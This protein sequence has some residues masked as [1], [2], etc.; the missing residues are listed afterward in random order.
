VKLLI[1]A[2]Q[3]LP[4]ISAQSVRISQ[5]ARRFHFKD[6]NL[7]IKIVVFDPEG[8]KIGKNEGSEDGIE[9]ERFNRRLLPASLLKPQSLNPL[10]LALW[11]YIASKEIKDFN[12]DVVLA[13]TPPFTPSIATYVASRIAGDEVAYAIDYRDDLGRVI[14]RM[15]ND[16]G[17]WIKYPLKAA[18]WIMSFLL[19]QSIK[20]ALFLSTVNDSL[21]IELLKENKNV[22]L[23]PNG[24]DA[25]E[26]ADVKGVGFDKSQVLAK[27]GIFDLESRIVT[28]LGD[29]NMP[30]YMPEAILE[31]MK[32]LMVQ[33]YRIAYVVIGDGSRRE[34]IKNRAKE[35]GIEDSVYLLG[36]KNHKEAMELLM[37][38]DVAFHTLQKGDPQAGHAIAT[39]VYEYLG[40]KLPILAVV[41]Y[42]SAV[43]RLVGEKNVGISVN[44]DE[45]ERIE[46][47]L[48]EILDH[49]EIYR[50]N[51][52]A[53][54]QYFLD[55]FDRNKGIDLLYENLI[56]LA[57]QRRD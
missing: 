8:R 31:P 2:K 1:F 43:S 14:N 52:E 17:F 57:P 55:K 11:I 30:Y 41:D 45:M 54:H 46:L 5:I 32:K 36:R 9:L 3:Y 44:W 53:N 19:L 48:R 12:P 35:L 21:Q 42:G 51:L 22:V 24:L 16:K 28:Y 39:K 50:K 56:E 37:A 33:G 47:G 29:L 13:T 25:K 15:A 27:N 20:N 26:L 40:C 34:V 18:N 38:S 7:Q 23:V 10:L 4:D 6:K 49:P